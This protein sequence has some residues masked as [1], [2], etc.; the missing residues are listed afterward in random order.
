[1]DHFV[2]QVLTGLGFSLM[3]L[4]EYKYRNRWKVHDLENLM[5]IESKSSS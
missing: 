3:N 1:M 4:I 5:R 2:H